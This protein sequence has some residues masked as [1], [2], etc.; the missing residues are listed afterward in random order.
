MFNGVATVLLRPHD[1]DMPTPRRPVLG[2][3]RT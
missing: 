1:V 2:T 3:I